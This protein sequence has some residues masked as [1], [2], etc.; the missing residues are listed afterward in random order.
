MGTHSLLQAAKGY[1][2]GNLKNKLFYHVSKGEV[3]DS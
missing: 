2:N 1:W 3:Y